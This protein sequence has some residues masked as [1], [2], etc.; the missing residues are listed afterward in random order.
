MV[1]A[2]Y[3][4]FNWLFLRAKQNF[5]FKILMFLK[6]M[7]TR[8]FEKI[9]DKTQKLGYNQGYRRCTIKIETTKMFKK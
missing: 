6:K 9:L 3:F 4:S 1:F 7:N 2:Y 5:A 8:N